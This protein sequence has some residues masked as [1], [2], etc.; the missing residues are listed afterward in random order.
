MK[1]IRNVL[2]KWG[3][4]II[5]DQESHIVFRYQLNYIQVNTSETD[6]SRAVAVTLANIFSADDEKEMF[7]GLRAC[8]ELNCN[9]LHVKLYIDA[10]ADLILASEFF[11]Q[12]DS[13]VEFLLEMSLESLIRAKKSFI[14]KYNE[15]EELGRL[16]ND[17]EEEESQD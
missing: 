7:L 10:E 12:S 3:F 17:D 15:L 4:P 13:E 9:L 5:K 14:D 6:T 11:Y 1:N 16:M 2:E 8:N